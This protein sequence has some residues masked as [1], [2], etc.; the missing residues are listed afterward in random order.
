MRDRVCETCG[1][2][3]QRDCEWEELTG[4][5]PEGAPCQF[6]GT[7]DEDPD[8]AREKREDRDRLAKEWDA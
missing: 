2:S 6:D 1:A 7:W 8:E 5:M 3:R 4:N